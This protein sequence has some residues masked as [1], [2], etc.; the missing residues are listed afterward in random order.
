MILAPRGAF[1][2]AQIN[3]CKYSMWTKLKTTQPID[4][5]QGAL[6][7]ENISEEDGVLWSRQYSVTV[8]S[9]LINKLFNDRLGK[10]EQFIIEFPLKEDQANINAPHCTRVLTNLGDKDCVID[11]YYENLGANVFFARDDLVL[12]HHSDFDLNWSVVLSPNETIIIDATLPT[13]INYGEKLLWREW[14]TAYRHIRESVLPWISSSC[15]LEQELTKELTD[16]G[17]EVTVKKDG[18][19]KYTKMPPINRSTS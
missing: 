15:E 8:H 10:F 4:Y 17:F 12:V 16:R 7:R 18:A 13:R 14:T 3:V 6:V 2:T 1:F 9:G 11:F 19:V 5:S